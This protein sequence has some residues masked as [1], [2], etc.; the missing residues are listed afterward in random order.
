MP[1]SANS[2]SA[3][4]ISEIPTALMIWIAM[5]SCRLKLECRNSLSYKSTAAS[6]SSLVCSTT[7]TA[8]SRCIL[9]TSAAACARTSLRSLDTWASSSWN[10][11]S[12]MY[13]CRSEMNAEAA[14]AASRHWSRS[15]I[16]AIKNTLSTNNGSC[17][18][19]HSRVRGALSDMC[20]GSRAVGS[21][22]LLQTPKA[23]HQRGQSEPGEQNGHHRKPPEL[24]RTSQPSGIQVSCRFEPPKMAQRTSPLSIARLVAL[25]SSLF[26]PS[27]SLPI[28]D[29]A[30]SAYDTLRLLSGR[31][32]GRCC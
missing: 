10:T 3:D 15:T 2:W 29:Q 13:R 18:F 14:N 27:Y 30:L 16:R 9:R 11:P 26:A 23:L 5:Q 24:G 7:L 17:P 12:L 1:A 28:P 22:S 20:R 32:A 31:S 8:E 25:L 21:L 6:T 4:R 19:I